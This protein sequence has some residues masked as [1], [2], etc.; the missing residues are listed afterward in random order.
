MTSDTYRKN[1][2]SGHGYWLDG[3][4]VIGVTTMMRGLKG[5]PET[6]FTETTAGYAVDHWDDL[7]KLP[8]SERI[9]DIAGATKRRFTG[10]GIRGTAVH[11]IAE[12]LIHGEEVAVPDDL[13]G[14]VEACCQFLDDYDVQPTLV[15]PALFS[16]R[17]H[18]GGSADFFAT[19]AKPHQ[20]QRVRVL[21][22][23]KT[24]ASG[25]WG[26]MAFQLAGYRYA[27]FY[28]DEDGE[29]QPVPEVDECWI[30]WLRDDGYD[31]VPMEVTPEVHLRLRYINQCRIADEECRNYKGDPLPK[32]DTVRRLLLRVAEEVPA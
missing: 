25:P 6:Y 13:R 30:V 29:E 8:P 17:Y 27:D 16:R 21:G 23:W 5:P 7:A 18:Y 12:Q 26:S 4:R 9:K 11:Q 14:R 24:S 2:A 20:E 31:V 3:Q 22:D 32:P 10:A 1:F 19:A 15:E 28:L